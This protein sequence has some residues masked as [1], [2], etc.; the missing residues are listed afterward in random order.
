MSTNLKQLSTAQTAVLLSSITNSS[1][2]S[3]DMDT[4]LPG[5]TIVWNGRETFDGNYAF[6]AADPSYTQYAL[7][8]R[9]SLP[10]NDIFDNWYEFTNWILEDLDVLTRVNWPYVTSG[11]A[12]I[13]KGTFTAFTNVQNMKDTTGAMG[14]IFDYLKVNAVLANKKII[15]TGHSLGGNI[16]NVY[17][18]YF[19]SALLQEGY[20]A[21]T[22]LYTF[23]APAAGNSNFAT[24]L[25]NKLSNAWH[26]ENRYD[27]VPK[28]PV[29]TSILEVASLFLPEPLAAEIMV[30][31]DGHDFTLKEA[32]TLLAGIFYLY[33]Y[34]QQSNNYTVFSNELDNQYE[35]NTIKDWL[36]QAGYQ[37]AISNYANFLNV[38]LTS[39]L[40]ERSRVV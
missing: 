9:G 28:F 33:D 7:A 16:A 12:L 21:D 2:P 26:Y 19:I 22:H 14:S 3:Q 4:L 30:T 27:I 17:A 35:N 20:S 39:E 40:A 24:D 25:D 37:H 10:P 1:N 23:A 32:I 8:I 29:S 5:W 11:E 31:H 36:C 6:I 38:S 13:S 18:S 34:K 15:I